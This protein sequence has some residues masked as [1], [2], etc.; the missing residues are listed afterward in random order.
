MTIATADGSLDESIP[1]VLTAQPGS[2]HVIAMVDLT[3]HEFAGTLELTP[4]WT[5]HEMLLLLSWDRDGRLTGAMQTGA[6]LDTQAIE[7]PDTR[8]G[9]YAVILGQ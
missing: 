8:S 1:L 5:K 9:P 7:D 4:G 6:A 3:D 2:K